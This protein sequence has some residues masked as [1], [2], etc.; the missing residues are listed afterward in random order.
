MA[1]E[2]SR[3][4]EGP[5]QGR[6]PAIPRATIRERLLA[7]ALGAGLLSV[8]GVA[9]WL[10]PDDRGH[11]T[12]EQLDFLP[13]MQACTWATALEAPCPTCGMTTSF[14]WAA[15]GDFAAAFATQPFGA[16]LSIL[17]ATAFWGSLH[18]A[19][20][21]SRLGRFAEAALRPRVLWTA[22]ALLLLAWAYK[23]GTW[24]G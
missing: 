10:V 21:G 13:G 20:T 12:H 17:A 15:E 19:L 8:L 9:A 1:T 11:G 4:V 22:G 2:A 23:A 5:S 24:T 16:L 3:K 14:T 6:R 18:V 7:A